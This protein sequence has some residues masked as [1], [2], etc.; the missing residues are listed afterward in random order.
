[1]ALIAVQEM[2]EYCPCGGALIK[3]VGVANEKVLHLRYGCHKTRVFLDSTAI[4]CLPVNLR[5]L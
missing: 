2:D 4:P 1:M 3:L 5:D